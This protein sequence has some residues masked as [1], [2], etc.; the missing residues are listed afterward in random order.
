MSKRKASIA[1]RG[2]GV[3]GLWQA[4]TLARRGHE[5]AVFERAERPFANACSVYAA[6]M[7]APQCEEETAEPLV[8]R[9]G[10][11]GLALWIET[12]PGTKADGSLVVALPRD[13][14]ELDRFARMTRGHKRIGSDEIAALEPGL[15]GRFSSGLYFAQ[16][17]HVAPVPAL[18]F[19][20]D[21]AKEAGAVSHF[22]RSEVEGDFDAVIDCRGLA[23][24]DRLTGLRGVRGERLI[25]RSGEVSLS[26]PVRLLHPRVPI[27]IVPW[28]DGL[29]MIGATLIESEETGQVSVRSALELLSAAYALEPAFGEAEIVSLGAGARPAFPDNSPRIMLDGDHIYVNG[30]YRHGFLLAPALAELVADYLEGGAIE[31]EIFIAD[32]A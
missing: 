29:F 3:V 7:L 30:L 21:A 23:A 20:L 1:I 5:V 6:A 25:V 27:Y 26:R 16:E 14:G 15:S 24:R 19:L 32:R 12:Y 9:L 10:R 4:L 22:G 17:G 8:N 31:T 13:R 28:G 18:E 2:A 11:R